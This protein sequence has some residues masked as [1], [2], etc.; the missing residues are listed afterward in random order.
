[1]AWIAPIYDRTLEDV[2]ALKEL[3]EFINTTG[4]DSILI[5]PDWYN[6]KGAL[7]A[8]DLNRI[9]GNIEYISDELIL[10][11][12]TVSLDMSNPIWGR[13]SYLLLSNINVIR[14]NVN[15]LIEKWHVNPDAPMIEFTTTMT[16]DDLN[17]IEENIYQLKSFIDLWK[18]NIQPSCGAIECGQDLVL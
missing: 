8:V 1:M 10:A 18:S 3:I 12:V 13:S 17:D 2:L 15:A 14:S 6:P 9:Q 16:Y 7:N 5:P 11:G 4:W